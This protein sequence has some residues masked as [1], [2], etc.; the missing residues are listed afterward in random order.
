MRKP[1]FLLIALGILAI[2]PLVMLLEN[3][4]EN[5]TRSATTSDLNVVPF[6]RTTTTVDFSETSFTE[7]DYES[8]SE[9]V[10]FRAKK[11]YTLMIYMNGSDLETDNAA[12]TVDLAEMLTSGVDTGKVNIVIFT[13]GTNRWQNNVVPSS[14]CAIWEISEGRLKGITGI[15]LL[16]MG[17]PGT[18]TG[19]INLGYSAFP[20]DRY[21]LIMWDHGGGAIAGFG[22]DEKF[23]DSSLTLLDMN[24]AFK[25]S[26]AA[27]HKME[28]LGF[29]SCLMATAEMAVVAADY[30]KYMI[31][32]EDT[33][34]LDGWDYEFLSAFNS[35][36]PLSGAEMGQIIV[37]SFMDF[38]GPDSDEV[39]TL[40]VMDLSRAGHVMSSMGMLMERCS[41]KLNTPSS[42]RKL[43]TRRRATK[44][45]GEGSPRDNQSDM[46]D[47]GDM[48]RRLSDIFPDEAG[49]LLRELE[50][51]VLYTRDNSDTQL[52]G[53]SA[54]YI[55]GGRDIGNLALETYRLLQMD[56]DYTGYL[57]G[58]FTVLT[59]SRRATRSSVSSTSDDMP[60]Q[61]TAWR[62]IGERPGHFA[63][64]SIQD[65]DFP[66][67]QWPKINGEYVCLFPIANYDRKTMFASPAIINDVEGNIIVVV[68]DKYPEGKIL[69]VRKND[70]LVIQKGFDEIKPEDKIFLHNKVYNFR[71]KTETWEKGKEISAKNGLALKWDILSNDLYISTETED[72]YGYINYTHPFRE[73][74]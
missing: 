72:A 14:E 34:P 60:V 36:Y 55:Y 12:G 13:G 21:A 20:A 48:A 42:F 38:Y 56:G 18:L 47:L 1:V 50:T 73:S 57:N 45:F 5:P 46:V 39:L 27:E 53:L 66:C 44:T 63:M 24:Y 70:G 11:P 68:G 40:S 30:A 62:D 16:D 69:G 8:A 6:R 31:A 19:F 33:E 71:D 58:F 25:K 35:N 2:T 9:K 23:D 51:A 4:E 41:D 74:S 26:A 43:A 59:S 67:D 3:P 37:D 32:A 64:V 7:W 28:W 61:L 65:D 22:Q 10:P 54:Y 29:D 15:G 49:A 17:D 52:D